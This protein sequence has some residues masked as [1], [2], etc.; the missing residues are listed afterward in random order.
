VE[1]S[2]LQVRDFGAG[3]GVAVRKFPVKGCEADYTLF[4]ERHAVG[5]VEAKPKGVTLSGVSEQTEN[6][7]AGFPQRNL[8]CHSYS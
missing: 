8:Q 7:L 5:V 4:V 1:A 2:R 6:Y 3:S